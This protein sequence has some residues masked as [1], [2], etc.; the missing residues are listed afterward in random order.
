MAANP[1][2]ALAGDWA[3]IP[4]ELQALPQWFV[5]DPVTKQPL[6]YSDAFNT[7]VAAQWTNPAHMMTFERAVRMAT[8]AGAHFGRAY[9][10]GMVFTAGDPFVVIDL[11]DKKDNPA[12]DADKELFGAIIRT[13][14]SY[15]EI[16]SS[17]RGA[18]IVVRAD[19]VTTNF[20]RDRVECYSSSRFMVMTGRVVGTRSVINERGTLIL[21]MTSQ[22]HVALDKGEALLLDDQA[23]ERFTDAEVMHRCETSANGEKFKHLWAG[24]GLHLYDG[25]D[26]RVDSA[27]MQF[28]WFH[29]RNK[30]QTFRLFMQSQ[31]AQREKAQKRQQDYVVN[32]T[33]R[34]AMTRL[35]ADEEALAKIEFAEVFFGKPPVRR[36]SNVIEL[37]PQ[38]TPE[39]APLDQAT[40][41]QPQFDISAMINKAIPPKVIMP[42]DKRVKKPL[43]L[44]A[45]VP[46][47]EPVGNLKLLVE[48]FEAASVLPTREMAV[49]AAMATVAGIIGAAYQTPGKPDGLNQ[50]FIVVGRSA[51]G[52][53]SM[54]DAM[55]NIRSA[56]KRNGK[57]P[58]DHRFDFSKYGSPKALFAKGIFKKGGDSFVHISSEWGSN[59]AAMKGR[60]DSELKA[61]ETIQLEMYNGGRMGKVIGGN[62][63]QDK[64]NTTEGERGPLAYTIL[65]ETN[66][67]DFAAAFSNDN[68]ENGFMSRITPIEYPGEIP[69]FNDDAITVVPKHI[70]DLIEQLETNAMQRAAMVPMAAALSKAAGAEAVAWTEDARRAVIDHREKHFQIAR[71][72]GSAQDGPDD[73]RRHL[74]TRANLKMLRTATL[75][76]V[77]ENPVKPIMELWMVEWAIALLQHSMSVF[78]R[79]YVSGDIGNA[80]SKGFTKVLFTLTQYLDGAYKTAQDFDSMLHEQNIVTRSFLSQ[81]VNSFLNGVMPNVKRPLDDVIDEMVKQGRLTRVSGVK[82]L[83]GVTRAECYQLIDLTTPGR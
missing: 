41:A 8:G 2:I 36:D 38:P 44:D 28:L 16:S 57:I 29:S 52:K 63:L 48:Y 17:G 18:H 61:Y 71:G 22:M 65:S 39:P 58:I 51:T 21:N 75:L 23:A 10:I 74:H 67:H 83:H 32:F 9:G 72:Y 66:P 14:D 60:M 3:N 49:A 24:Q 34:Q 50:Y 4:A 40:E 31:P 70:V 42:V 11:D 5:S 55:G 78:L 37:H 81:R 43:E 19:G 59:I 46:V 15:T 73:M 56:V 25:D 1:A 79:R 27:L 20:R 13:L 6:M 33:L 26:S 54:G 30:C 7:L 64:E 45:F 53:E 76:A 80:T 68:A 62:V 82:T 35:Q 77:L 47:P 69:R 12:T